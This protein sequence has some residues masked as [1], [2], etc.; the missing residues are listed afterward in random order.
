MFARQAILRPLRNPVHGG[1]EM[2]VAM[3]ASTAFGDQDSFSKFSEVVQYFARFIILDERSQRYGDF[4]IL[5]IL[6]VPIASFSV[7]ATV[8]TKGMVVT[9]FEKRIFVRI[10]NQVNTAAVAA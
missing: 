8:R 1:C 2:R 5:S 9:E 3:T 10:G 4:E 6:P 7:S